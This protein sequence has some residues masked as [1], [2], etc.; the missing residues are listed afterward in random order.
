MREVRNGSTRKIHNAIREHGVDRCLYEV[1]ERGFSSIIDLALAEI[2]QIAIHNSYRRGLNSTPGGDGYGSSDLS[3]LGK[4]D[5]S[6]IKDVFAQRFAEYN[7]K[8]WSGL[9][10]HERKEAT[11]HLLAE[12]VIA[13][14]G[15]TLARR[16]ESDPDFAQSKRK[17]LSR[18]QAE[19]RE[20][21]LAQ[22]KALSEKASVKN[23]KKVIV[24]REDGSVE[25]YPSRVEFRKRTGILYATLLYNMTQGREHYKGFKLIEAENE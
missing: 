20:L 5:I 10:P 4:N 24:Q 11:S 17:G 7:A 18:W 9:S 8:K 19:N 15:A 12:E 6:A 25:T 22:N 2:N 3:S 16:Y 1:I 23:S 21:F 14:R 13:R